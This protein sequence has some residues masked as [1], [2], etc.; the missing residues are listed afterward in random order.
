VL[1]LEVL[2]QRFL[3]V[4][5]ATDAQGADE[6]FAEALQAFVIVVPVL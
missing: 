5:R 3:I 4:F 6:E 2:D 1:R